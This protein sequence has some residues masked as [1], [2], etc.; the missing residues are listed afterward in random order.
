MTDEAKQPVMDKSGEVF[1]IDY[2]RE[3]T[4]SAVATGKKGRKARGKKT[5]DS[6]KP[7]GRSLRATGRTE[8]LVLKAHP[9]IV[10]ALERHVG[11]GKKSLWVEEAIIAK[12]EAEGYDLDA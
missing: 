12:L 5:S 11:K 1:D 4:K 7:D 9:A 2:Y 8:H 3:L 6:A 10:E